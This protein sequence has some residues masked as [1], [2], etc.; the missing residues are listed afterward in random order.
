MEAIMPIFLGVH[1]APDAAD[2]AAGTSMRDSWEAYCK[3]AIGM[4]L[5]P[6]GAVA[7][8]ERGIG[9]CQT[10]ASTI[11]EVKKAHEEANVPLKDVYEV[12]AFPP[13]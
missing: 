2:P 11:D 8:I 13:T 4:G 7:S 3:A 12:S 5:Q 9:F 10:D 1:E 6:L